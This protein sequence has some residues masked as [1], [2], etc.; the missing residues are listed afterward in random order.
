MSP[1]LDRN[2]SLFDSSSFQL[3]EAAGG[4]VWGR[5]RVTFPSTFTGLGA[6]ASRDYVQFNVHV[7]PT[8]GRRAGA[9]RDRRRGDDP[10]RYPRRVVGVAAAVRLM[11]DRKRQPGESVWPGSAGLPS[12]GH[13]LSLPRCDW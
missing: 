3:D 10:G 6:D 13:A 12:H 11:K 4:G 8:L 9:D 2:A 1:P 7:N 5:T